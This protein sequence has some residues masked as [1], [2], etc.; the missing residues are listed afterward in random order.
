MKLPMALT[1]SGLVFAGGMV[2]AGSPANAATGQGKVTVSPNVAASAELIATATD[3]R[4]PRCR[5]FVRGHYQRVRGRTVFVRGYWLP[6]G[7]R[8]RM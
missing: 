5:R 3:D 1:V 2:L 6:R 7:C 8:H 4:P